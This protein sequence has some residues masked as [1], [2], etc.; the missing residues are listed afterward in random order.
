M[1]ELRLAETRSQ[2][3]IVGL[4][5][6]LTIQ[7]K[8]DLGNDPLCPCFVLEH[9]VTVAK[10]AVIAGQ[11][12]TFTGLPVNHMDRLD[13]LSHLDTVGTDILNGCAAYRPRDQCQIGETMK[14]L[15]MTPHD[16]IMPGLAGA[17]PDS[18]LRTVI[19]EYFAALDGHQQCRP[20]QMIAENHITPATQ[21]IGNC[22]P[23]QRGDLCLQLI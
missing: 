13:M 10:F 4:N 5:R 20:G 1:G 6:R 3:R 11:H 9:T 7:H 16:K 19:A 15:V 23:V 8:I 14:T 18:H 17:Y 12:S 22:A 21:H 2:R